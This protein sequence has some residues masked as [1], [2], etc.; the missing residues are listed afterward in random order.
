MFLGIL[1]VEVGQNND[2]KAIILDY[3]CYDAD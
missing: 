1:Y 2:E 3:N